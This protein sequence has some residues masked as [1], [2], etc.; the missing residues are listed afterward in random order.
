[1]SRKTRAAAENLD[2]MGK[3]EGPQLWHQ[4]DPEEA[5]D[6]WGEFEEPELPP[7]IPLTIGPASDGPAGP[8]SGVD[9]GTGRMAAQLNWTVSQTDHPQKAIRVGDAEIEVDA[10]FGPLIFS[11]NALGCQT[12]TSCGGTG[13]S[14]WSY[15]MFTEDGG[16]EFANI[17]HRRLAPLGYEQ[18]VLDHQLRDAD[19]RM[20]IG[21]DYPF[22]IPIPV[23]PGGTNFTLIWKLYRDELEAMMADLLDA[24]GREL[25]AQLRG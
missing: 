20:K 24:L 1:V 6:P 2:P 23:D 13:D 25:Q 16:R 12:I 4:L 8:A 14:E 18:P 11:L 9:L 5:L 3:P 19:W 21:R 15:V 17:W 7:T 10:S 22:P